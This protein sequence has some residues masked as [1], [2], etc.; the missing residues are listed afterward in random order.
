MCMPEFV[1]FSL[2]KNSCL[3]KEKTKQNQENI[4]SLVCLCLF[5]GSRPSSCLPL[6]ANCL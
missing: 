6:L 3:L 1:S 5:V 2:Y 4:Y